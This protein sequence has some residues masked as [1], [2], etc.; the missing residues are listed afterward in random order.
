MNKLFEGVH[1]ESKR[2]FMAGAAAI[3]ATLAVSIVM[4]IGAGRFLDY[5]PAIE[6]SEKLLA[7]VRP[8]SVVFCAG[9]T[10]VE[11]LLKRADGAAG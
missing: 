2:T 11:Y 10:L 8:L 3:A 5:Y 9:S 6:A 7:S 1:R 4:Y